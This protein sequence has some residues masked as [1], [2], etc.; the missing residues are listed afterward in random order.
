MWARAP[1]GLTDRARRRDW[2]HWLGAT[3]AP[4]GSKQ[5]RSNDANDFKGKPRDGSQTGRR[6]RPGRAARLA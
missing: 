3:R 1:T 5:L 2:N 4:A 6:S